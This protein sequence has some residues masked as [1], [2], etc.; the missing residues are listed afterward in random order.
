MYYLKRGFQITTLNV[1]GEFASL[2]VLIQD[3]PGGTRVN[4][5]SAS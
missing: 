2:Q 5:S 1:D 4:L 3:M